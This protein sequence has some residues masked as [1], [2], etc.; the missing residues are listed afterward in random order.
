MLHDSRKSGPD[1]GTRRSFGRLRRLPSGRWQA[2]YTGPDGVLYKH[3]STFSTED[4]AR[5]WLA[6]ERKLVDLD[7]WTTPDSRLAQKRARGLTF[8]DYADAWLMRRTTGGEPLKP[9]TL[10]DYRRYLD[11]HLR[12]ALGALP[13]RA[14]NEVRVRAW[15]ETMIPGAPSER[16][17]SYSLLRAIMTTAVKEKAAPANPCTIDGGGQVRRPR[18]IRIATLDELAT[19][20]TAMPER[21]QLAILLGAWCALRYGEIAELRRKDIDLPAGVVR[22]SRGA[23]WPTGGEVTVGTP[24]SEAGVRD[25]DIP[26]HLVPAFRAHL[27][28]HTGPAPDALLFPTNSGGQMHPRTFGNKYHKARVIAGRPDLH[29]HD[30][31]HTGAVLAAQSGATIADLMARLGHSTPRMAM[32]YQHT[33]QGRGQMIAAALSKLAVQG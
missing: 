23:T 29:F 1:K 9:R 27:K 25:V 18:R 14:I 7:N 33:A 26:P 2:A 8:S 30:L 4:A 28:D 24:K 15:Y 21:L 12:P 16:A 11:R 10:A 17:H 32:H 5:G 6:G 13:V 22:V 3:P 19:I 31:R 20:T